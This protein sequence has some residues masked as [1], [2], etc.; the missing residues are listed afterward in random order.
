MIKSKWSIGWDKIKYENAEEPGGKVTSFVWVRLKSPKILMLEKHSGVRQI[1]SCSKIPKATPSGLFP[2][3]F[4]AYHMSYEDL[5]CNA[6]YK[7]IFFIFIFNTLKGTS[8]IRPLVGKARVFFS[9]SVMMLLNRWPWCRLHGIPFRSSKLGTSCCEL[10]SC[11]QTSSSGLSVELH[12]HDLHS[13][14]DSCLVSIL[15][16]AFNRQIPL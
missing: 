1:T 3:S 14:Q 11:S 9:R 7:S 13:E 6:F 16:E 2:R 8:D 12:R 10:Q 5:H 15:C 4:T